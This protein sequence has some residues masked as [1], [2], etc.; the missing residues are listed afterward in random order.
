MAP[1][2]HFPL[3]PVPQ[4]LLWNGI[5]PRMAAFKFLWPTT[6]RK[7]T[8]IYDNRGDC[9]VQLSLQMQCS[10]MIVLQQRREINKKAIV[11]RSHRHLDGSE[12]AL[13][14]ITPSLPAAHQNTVSGLKQLRCLL[15]RRTSIWCKKIW[16]PL[17]SVTEKWQWLGR[18]QRTQSHFAWN[19]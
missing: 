13:T 8:R 9:C 3:L 6:N 2:N 14:V 1:K 19:M 10:K 12:T 4:E 7:P 18:W 17:Q 15:W 16:L 11:R 5:K